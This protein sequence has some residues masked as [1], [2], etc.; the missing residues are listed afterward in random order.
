MIKRITTALALLLAVNCLTVAQLAQAQEQ[1]VDGKHYVT[2]QTPLLT[3][4][5]DKIE[6]K[7][8]FWYGCI[9]CFHFEPLLRNWENS[10]PEDV[11][12][13]GSPAVWNNRMLIHAKAYYT[14][15]VLGVLDKVHEPLFEALNSPERPA[16]DDEDELAEFFAAHGVDEAAFRE[17]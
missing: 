7:E 5:S 11:Y 6:V 1:F 8:F 14:A 17:A 9:H 3:R 15:W 12:L 4:D 10:A 2:L 16:L 13:V